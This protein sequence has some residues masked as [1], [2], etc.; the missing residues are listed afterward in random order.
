M[1]QSKVQL[2]RRAA[3]LCVQGEQLEGAMAR[4]EQVDIGVFCSYTNALSRLFARLGLARP[5]DSDDHPTLD[6]Y[7]RGEL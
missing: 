2:A 6:Q 4:G 5:L 3:A 7:L 1:S